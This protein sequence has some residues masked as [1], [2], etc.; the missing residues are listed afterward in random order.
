MSLLHHLFDTFRVTAEEE[1]G[2][3]GLV[4]FGDVW[5]VLGLGIHLPNALESR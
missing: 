1:G 3:R 2:T 4:T 5:L